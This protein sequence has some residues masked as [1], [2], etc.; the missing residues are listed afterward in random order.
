MSEGRTPIA[1]V[2][3]DHDGTLVDSIPVI[4]AATNRVF[5]AHGHPR[6]TAEQIVPGMVLPT[7]QRLGRH[8]AVSD[9]AAQR[10]LAQAFYAAARDLGPGLATLYPAVQDGLCALAATGLRLAVV[11]NNEGVFVRAV[12]AALGI[13]QHFSTILGE[14]DMPAPKPDP[15][16]PLLAAAKLCLAPAACCFVGD[17]RP[18]ADAARDAGMRSIG[19]TWGTHGRAEMLGMGF[20]VVVDSVGELTATIH[21]WMRSVPKP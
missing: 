19:V 5:A 7:G 10:E 8:F 11:S 14:E 4:V 18:D 12:T 17:S 2:L 16:G 3:F 20:T 9:V 21:G 13:A 15:S 1:G 6:L